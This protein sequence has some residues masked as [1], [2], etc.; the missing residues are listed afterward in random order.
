ML[1]M[2]PISIIISIPLA[3]HDA[4]GFHHFWVPEYGALM[5][6]DAYCFI[7]S[8][9]M[10]AHAL[11]FLTMPPFQWAVLG[12]GLNILNIS[13]AGA[14]YSTRMQSTGW[15]EIRHF[16]SCFSAIYSFIGIAIIRRF[17]YNWYILKIIINKHQ[18]LTRI[19]FSIVRKRGLRRRRASAE[20]K[21]S[22]NETAKSQWQ[23]ASP[24]SPL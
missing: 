7:L 21:M 5:R 11:S 24:V 6:R 1:L 22:W 4:D 17:A 20:I 9:V 3:N 19:N 2:R 14:G 18:P 10:T 8:P 12:L 23:S 16:I 13:I 15:N